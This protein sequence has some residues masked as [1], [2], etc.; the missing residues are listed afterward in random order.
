MIG[1]L[2]VGSWLAA[3]GAY[4]VARRKPLTGDLLMVLGVLL[5]AIWL[6]FLWV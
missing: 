5:G 4:V 2:A 6:G 1:T 3:S